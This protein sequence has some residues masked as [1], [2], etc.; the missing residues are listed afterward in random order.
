MVS[1]KKRF[2]FIIFLF[3]L[4]PSVVLSGA[5]GGQSGFD[6]LRI[7]QGAKSV[8]MGGAFTAQIADLYGL[9]YNPASLVGVKDLESTFTY[10]NHFLDIKSGFIGFNKVMPNAGHLGIGLFYM[11]YGEIRR[12][13][14]V[15]NDQGSFSPGDFVVNAAYAN[16]LS[17]GLRYG[18]AIKYIQSKID[19]YTSNAVALD[20]GAIYRVESQALNIGVGISN[21]G[22]ALTAF[23][24]EREKLP[25]SF[26]LGVSKRLAHLPLCLSLDVFRFL[27]E[28]SDQFLG[29]YWALGGE[30]TI[31]QYFFLRWGYNSRGSE[32]KVGTDS[33]RFAG[34]SLGFGI[35]F[36]NY[37]IDYGYSSFGALGSM[38]TF[39]VTVPF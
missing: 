15:G 32:E 18:V 14:I 4:L 12:T 34:V 30:F 38:N 27:H 16:S 3:L 17:S 39:T 36:K 20:V 7:E 26:R 10:L 33:D 19:Q 25:T 11:N 5:S 23:I 2:V 22:T 35:R 28:E 13:D 1:M 37:R 24:D 29:L 21:L 6:F 9:A 31:S 8:A